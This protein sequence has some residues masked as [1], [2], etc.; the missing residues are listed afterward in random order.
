MDWRREWDSNPPHILGMC[1]L[2][3]L[4]CH[5]CHFTQLCSTALHDIALRAFSLGHRQYRDIVLSVLENRRGR[6]SQQGSN[7]LSLGK[8]PQKDTSKSPPTY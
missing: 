6:K 1:K 4:D 5:P 3:N 8:A 7:R 2:Q